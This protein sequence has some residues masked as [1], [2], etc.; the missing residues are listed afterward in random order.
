MYEKLITIGDID[1]AILRIS[2]LIDIADNLSNLGYDIYTFRDYLNKLIEEEY[3]MKYSNLDDGSNAV[4]IMTI[5]K[6]KGLEYHICYYSG[7]YKKFNIQD[8]NDRFIYDN[9]YGIIAPYFEEGIHETITKYLTKYHYLEEEVGERIRLFYVALTRAK[10]K[11]I[12]LTPL[13]EEIDYQIDNNG[14]IEETIRRGYRSFTQILESI[15]TKIIKYYKQIDINTLGITNEYLFNKTNNTKLKTTQ[16]T[17]T[18]KEINISTEEELDTKHFSKET[19]TLINKDIYNNMQL[20]LKVHEILELLDFK[21]PNLD[22]IEDPFIKEKVTKFLNN[23]I[24]KDI[25]K[26][27]IYKEYEFLYE[28]NNIEYHGIIDLMIEYDNNIDIIDYKL[29]NIKDENYLKQL[30]GYKE[31]ISKITNKEIHIYLYSIINEKIEEL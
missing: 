21:K 14:T 16:E 27:N 12:M 9:R 3:D 23:P 31:Y 15:K 6:S 8:L 29:N 18:V 1:N 26:S 10:E 4:K 2:K 11:M 22:L 24:L 30:N 28:E 17:I 13:C 20:G 25:N 19:H 7:L 5:H